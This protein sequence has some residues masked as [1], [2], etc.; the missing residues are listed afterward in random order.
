MGIKNY[1]WGLDGYCQLGFN[2]ALDLSG[3][4]GFWFQLR[5]DYMFGFVIFEI[6]KM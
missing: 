6:S 4:T 2:A 1:W 3:K 5:I